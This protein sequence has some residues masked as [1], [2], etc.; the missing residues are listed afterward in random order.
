M[1]VYQNYR[2]SCSTK[3]YSKQMCEVICGDFCDVMKEKG[4]ALAGGH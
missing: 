2:I 4:I 3:I 1:I